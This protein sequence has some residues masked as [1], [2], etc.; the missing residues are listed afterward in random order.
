MTTGKLIASAILGAVAYWFIDSAIDSHLFLEGTFWSQALSPAPHE[1]FMRSI[2]IAL[3]TALGLIAV[4]LSRHK[5]ADEV[6]CQKDEL[7]RMTSEMA[8]VGG[9]EF[10]VATRKGTWTDEV[11][12]IHDL[13]PD[14]E[15]NVELGLSFYTP[16]SRLLIDK[17]IQGAI[18][19]AKPYDLELEI[20]TDQGAHKWVRTIG[21]PLLKGGSV[22]KVKGTFQDITERRKMED[23]LREGEDRYR[24]LVENSD[25]LICTHDLAGSILSVN[26]AVP[27][28]LGYP[29]EAIVGRNM[30][31]LLDPQYHD[32][33][34]GYLA[35]IKSDGQAQ[36]IMHIVNAKGEVRLWE[37]HNTLRTEGVAQPIVRGMAHDVTGRLLAEKALKETTTRLESVMDS[38]NALIYVADMKTHELLFMNKYGRDIWGEIAGKTCWKTLQEGQSGPC[39]FCTNDRL[40]KPDGTPSEVYAWEFQNTVNNN[41]YDCRD[42]AIRWDD[43]RL[44]RMEIATD[45]TERKKLEDQLRQAQKMEAIG[46]LAGGVAHDFNN[47]LS[48]IIGYGHL[49]MMKMPGDDPNRHNIEQILQSA[50]RATALT[51]SL[52]TFSRKQPVK[53]ET[54]ELNTVISKFE[55]FL[56]RLLREDIEMNKRYTSE[57]MT[58]MADRGQIEQV[59]MNLVTNARDAMPAKGMLTL[60]TSRMTLDESFLSAHGYGTPGEYAV[61]AVSDTGCGM[62]AETRRKIFEP[63]FTTKEVGK[64]TG[65]GLATVYGIV[66]SHGGFIN[67]YSESDKGTVFHVYLPLVPVAAGVMEPVTPS[68]VPPKG[69]TE[70]ILLAEDDAILRKMTC[71]VLKHMGYTVIEAKNG[72]EAVEKFIENKDII[73]LVILD[74]IM[75][76]MNGKEAHKEISVLV[77][78]VRCIFMSGYAEDIFTKDGI[79]LAEVTFLSKPVTPSVLLNKVREVLDQ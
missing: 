75:P 16:E 28:S 76:K 55:K 57:K 30:R 40:V 54:L 26:E 9:W 52:L 50:E 24:D 49:T 67:V 46:Q 71:T 77:P 64:G 22:V 19:S 73:R 32:R 31:L 66:K 61:L 6:L 7:L 13:P 78:R 43:G 59:V 34:D 72:Q 18:G 3:L 41:W 69:G 47:I 42:Q 63:F 62:D 53:K 70:T 2:V 37:Y 23:A 58:I 8:K 36:G 27:R 39:V 35:R 11:A 1:I 48:A 38:I 45:I 74:G 15:T 10:D 20:M 25:D 14:Q 17:G 68:P 51:Q 44:V 79:L 33:F 12:R 65:L 21:F 4:L 56:L 29:L 60:E 5:K